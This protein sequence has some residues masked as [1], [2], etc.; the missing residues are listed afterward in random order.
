[1]VGSADPA[2]PQKGRFFL[3]SPKTYTHRGDLSGGA[4]PPDRRSALSNLPVE[5]AST[6]VDAGFARESDGSAPKRLVPRTP[7]NPKKGDFSWYHL[8]PILI[9]GPLRRS[10]SPCMVD[11]FGQV[12]WASTTMYSSA[13][14]CRPALYKPTHQQTV[15]TGVPAGG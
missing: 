15:P 7:R 14:R 9:G 8:K 11:A 1:M 5:W 3:V 4:H 13:R 6:T 10:P 2:E 12:E